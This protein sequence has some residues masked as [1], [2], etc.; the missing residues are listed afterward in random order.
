MTTTS[1]TAQINVLTSQIQKLV[2]GC[3]VDGVFGTDTAMAIIRRLAVP[4]S[5]P[6]P[7]T[8]VAPAGS[9]STGAVA[10][11]AVDERSQRHIDSLFPYVR[12]IAVRFLH[13]CKA[14][15]IEARIISGTR[16]YA[17]QDV[18]YEQ[19]RTREGAIVTNA[20]GGFSNH[21]FGIAFD[22][23]VF[24]LTGKYLGESPDYAAA[25]AIGK[26]L[27]LTWGGD[28]SSFPDDAHFELRP[29]W[30]A[31]LPEKAMLAEFRRRTDMGEVLA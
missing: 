6:H 30:A 12:G 17:Q 26:T 29:G 9:G 1:G 4:P 27:K 5:G 19:G 28:W 13:L 7:Q 24:D 8:S 3:E 23:G 11:P 2:G 21:N 18:L 15:G 16:T 20:R 31:R 22:I 10:A 14:A 25:G